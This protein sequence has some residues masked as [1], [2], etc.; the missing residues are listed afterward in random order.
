MRKIPG[1]DMANLTELC[2][3]EGIHIDPENPELADAGA[4][5]HFVPPSGGRYPPS[6]PPSQH[7]PPKG[8]PAYPPPPMGVGYN[9]VQFQYGPPYPPPPHMIH[10]PPITYHPQIHP[11]LQQQQQPTPQPATPTAAQPTPLPSGPVKAPQG[12]DPKMN[13]MSHPEVG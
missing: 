12:Q 9:G 13:D 11:E 6:A 5:Y 7:S 1:F 4:S 2:A 10:A 8:Y 3:R